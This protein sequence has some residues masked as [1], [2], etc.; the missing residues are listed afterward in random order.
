MTEG[1]ASTS[2]AVNPEAVAASP[3]ASMAAT[4]EAVHPR[5]REKLEK[6][7]VESPGCVVPFEVYGQLLAVYL[8]DND[9]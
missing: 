4:E 9:L 5:L 2:S 6:M 1:K 7:E 3:A 8:Y